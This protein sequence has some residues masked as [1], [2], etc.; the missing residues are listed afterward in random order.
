MERAKFA[1]AKFTQ[2]TWFALILGLYGAVAFGQGP[3]GS[4]TIDVPQQPLAAALNALAEQGEMEILYLSKD[5]QSLETN[6]IQGEYDIEQALDLLLA[7]TTLTYSM[8]GNRR[9]SVQA[10]S[11]HA[12]SDIEEFDMSTTS[13]N[14]VVLAAVASAL[15]GGVV[16]GDAVAQEEGV[17]VAQAD[18]A[19]DEHN[20]FR[21]DIHVGRSRRDGPQA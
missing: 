2:V 21:S 5:V 8:D 13:S 19:P 4:L 12:N 11:E 20:E 9:I 18:T 17:L 6:G 16:V 1:M 3:N 10:A 7:D 15:T 14:R